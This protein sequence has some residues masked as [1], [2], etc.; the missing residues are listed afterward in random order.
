LKIVN[1][2]LSVSIRTNDMG[3]QRSQTIHKRPSSIV[4]LANRDDLIREPS[5]FLCHEHAAAS[6]VSR[7]NLP[8]RTR[9]DLLPYKNMCPQ[10]STKRRPAASPMARPDHWLVNRRLSLSKVPMFSIIEKT[11]G[12]YISPV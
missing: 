1:E 6:A 4:P 12:L 9:G 2:Y 5:K 11:S 3:E 10:R 7:D 8:T